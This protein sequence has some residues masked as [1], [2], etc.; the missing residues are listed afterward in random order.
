M[1]TRGPDPTAPLWRAAQVFRLL[2]CVYALGFQIAVNSDLRRPALGWVL[3]AVLIGWSVAVAIA[4][5]RSFGRRPAWVIAEIAVVVVLMLSTRVV[6]TG[7]W[8]LDNQA[9]PTTLWASNA[10][11]SAALQFGPAGGMLT[12]V[13]VTAANEAVKGY[14]NVNLGRS[15]TIVIELAVGLAVG[16]AARTARRAH[17]E[18][19]RAA[20]LS[21][22]LH[23]RERLSR[24]VHDGVIQ[25]LAL[26]AKRGHQIGGDTAELA[27]LASEQ[28]RALR[29]WLSSADAEQDGDT[30]T[31]DLGALLRRRAS[32]QVSMSLPGAPVPLGRGVAAEL[33]AAVGNALDNVRL[34]A[35][36]NAH[37]YVLLEDTGDAVAVTVRDDGVG[38]AAGR[39]DEAA[40]QGRFG[41]TKSIV[42]RLAALGG[43]AQLST[44]TGEGT[45]WELR[46]PRREGRHE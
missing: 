9:W 19:Q 14:V 35:G 5:L 41:V 16:M 36:P 45:E 32:D 38:I 34:H 17:D 4:Y 3:L 33:D 27:A 30:Q 21:A 37:A 39:L 28:E 11:I 44:N 6:A 1:A 46:V 23:E 18:L 31:V 15:A 25:V 7:Q 42:G 40:S 13:A 10:T 43:T 29:R 8:A 22:A 20:E 2:S 12:G 26:V 24:Q